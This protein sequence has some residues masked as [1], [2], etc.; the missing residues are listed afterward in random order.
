MCLECKGKPILLS[1]DDSMKNYY[2]AVCEYFASLYGDIKQRPDQNLNTFV[3]DVTLLAN[4]V[5]P[6]D[7]ESSQVQAKGAFFKGCIHQF[8]TDFE[9]DMSKSTTLKEAVSEV[10]RLVESATNKK[11]LTVRPFHH[12]DLR[13]L[14]MVF[15]LFTIFPRENHSPD[16]G[17]SNSS[18][19]QDRRNFS[20]DHGHRDFSCDWGHWDVLPCRGH[21]GL[22]ARGL[23]DFSL[24]RSH[25]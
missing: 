8:E 3:C 21:C 23:H 20:S 14:Q 12:Q 18:Q 15:F 17:R 10:K 19:K 13:V 11:V 6:S 7:K 16:W 25:S 4:K 2:T 24:E 9:F 1:L 22:S 5:F